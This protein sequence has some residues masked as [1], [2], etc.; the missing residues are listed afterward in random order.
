MKAKIVSIAKAPKYDEVENTI[1]DATL[2]VAESHDCVIK[3]YSEKKY[4]LEDEIEIAI[5]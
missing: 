4:N 2:I 3:F 5:K 1:K